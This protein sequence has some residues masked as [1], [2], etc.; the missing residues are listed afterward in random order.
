[1]A[2]AGKRVKSDWA[3]TTHGVNSYKARV[4]D[5]A[6]RRKRRTSK[7]ICTYLAQALNKVKGEGKRVSLRSDDFKGKDKVRHLYRLTLFKEDYYAL[8]AENVV[9]TL[10]TREM[11]ENDIRRGGLEFTAGEPFEDLAA[12]FSL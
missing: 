5:P 8:C 4:N 7:E 6:V 2:K 11:I 9:I 10:F 1:M 12:T 3:V